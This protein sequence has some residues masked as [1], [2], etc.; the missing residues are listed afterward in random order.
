MSYETIEVRKTTPVIGAEIFGV[1]VPADIAGEKLWVEVSQDLAH[2]DVLIDDIVRDFFGR[3]GWITAPILLLLLGIDVAIF[4]RTLRPIVAASNMSPVKS[5]YL[6]RVTPIRRGR[7]IDVP[8]P[9]SWPKGECASP[10]VADRAATT[11]SQQSTSSSPPAR[12]FPCTEAM[13]GL[14]NLSIR[15]NTDPVRRIRRPN[16]ARAA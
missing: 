9:G 1:S 15:L 14:G 13:T 12:A 8:P 11:R 6:A 16:L 2:R 7:R 5:M 10:K 3:V 4:R